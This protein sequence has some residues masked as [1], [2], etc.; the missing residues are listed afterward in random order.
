MKKKEIVGGT[1]TKYV[2]A[3]NKQWPTTRQ[4]CRTQTRGSLFFFSPRIARMQ[5]AA[6]HST[7]EGRPLEMMAS[8]KEKKGESIS[9]RDMR[10]T[11]FI[12]SSLL[13]TWLLPSSMKAH[14][15]RPPSSPFFISLRFGSF[16]CTLFSA[17]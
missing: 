14:T 3:H 13:S 9:R 7:G 8:A 1:G 15:K 16:H 2:Y 5:R 11:L 12:P 10:T 4:K 17:C 6:H